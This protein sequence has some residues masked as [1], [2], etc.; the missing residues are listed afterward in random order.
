MPTLT[1]DT[2]E[3]NTFDGVR[4]FLTAP[5]DRDQAVLYMPGCFRAVVSLTLPKR[6][7]F[8]I[9]DRATVM[10]QMELRHNYDWQFAYVQLYTT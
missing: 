10:T 1:V 5:L 9:L 2:F 8:A 4:I 7:A 6:E 3:A